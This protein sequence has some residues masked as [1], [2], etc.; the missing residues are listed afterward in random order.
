MLRFSASLQWF[1]L[2]Q[3]DRVS[4][5]PGNP[6]RVAGQFLMTV[7]TTE[8][9]QEPPTLCGAEERAV[10]EAF[11]SRRRLSIDKCMLDCFSSTYREA[12]AKFLGAAR[13]SGAALST[14]RLTSRNG[15]EDEELATDVASLGNANSGQVL[16]IISG[17]HGVEGHA[18]SGCQTAFLQSDLIAELAA[19]TRIVLVHAINPYG[20]AYSRR[21]N[22]DNI[23]LNRNFVDFSQP[24][25]PNPQYAKHARLYLPAGAAWEDYV[26]A[27]DRLARAAAVNGGYQFLKKALQP[28]QYEFPDGLYYGGTEP[29]WSNRT[30]MRIC[31]E[32]LKGCLRAA[33]L[34][35]HTGL[36]PPGVGELLFV[37][38]RLANQC[39]RYFTSPV[40]C[41]GGRE[42]VSASVQGPLITAVHDHSG[43]PTV[44]YGALEF[45]TVPVQENV[46][47]QI[48]ESWTHR[49]LSPLDPRRQAS[50]QRFKDAYY[51]DDPRWKQSVIERS[52][53]I[54]GGL[55]RCL[56]E[57]AKL[58][59]RPAHV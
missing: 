8:E 17:T 38:S 49:H 16:M 11:V 55:H 26:E 43:V 5:A 33:V 42:S 41:A 15:P 53:E 3:G 29:S 22:E 27:R 4:R 54:I 20:F 6:G 19:S 35:I 9:I 46:E 10:G 52:R 58:T 7:L 59:Q 23:D 37:D 14:H 28:G 1:L 51:C 36:G 18:G 30:L 32:A 2:Y 40:S 12:R 25:P 47:A 13:A 39:A 34:D 24:L 21:T 50:V 57:S 48:L 31:D 45:G 56:S 44:I